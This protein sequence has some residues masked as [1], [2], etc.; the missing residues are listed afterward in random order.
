MKSPGVTSLYP[1]SLYKLLNTAANPSTSNDTTFCSYPRNIFAAFCNFSPDKLRRFSN[2]VNSE[3]ARRQ[4]SFASKSLRQASTSVDFVAG[5]LVVAWITFAST[6]TY[7]P[8]AVL[9]SSMQRFLSLLC[10]IKQSASCCFHGF[11]YH[12]FQYCFWH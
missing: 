3:I 9:L 7:L 11:L 6:S 8:C 12:L 5:L 10:R 1:S 2:T 4:P